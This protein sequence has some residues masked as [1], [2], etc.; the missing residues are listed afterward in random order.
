MI[1]RNWIIC[2]LSQ[3]RLVLNI[4]QKALLWFLRYLDHAQTTDRQTQQKHQLLSGSNQNALKTYNIQMLPGG[5]KGTWPWERLESL[6]ICAWINKCEEPSQTVQRSTHLL[7]SGK[8][9]AKFSFIL[10][11]ISD[12]MFITKKKILII[13]FELWQNS[14]LQILPCF[15][16]STA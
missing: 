7:M 12:A 5:L 6:R 8:S 11:Q 1:T 16:S 10:L 15:L 13:L 3:S 9:K 4:H 14:R 2:S